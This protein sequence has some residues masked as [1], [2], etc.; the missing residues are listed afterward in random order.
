MQ[1]LLGNNFVFTN[2]STGTSPLNYKWTFGDGGND[3]QVNSIHHYNISGTY[4]VNL[5]ATTTAGCADTII[6]PAIVH[7]QPTASFTIVANGQCSNN[8][9]YTFTNTSTIST[10]SINNSWSFGDGGTSNLAS[11]THIYTSGT[12]FPVRLITI[13]DKGCRDTANQTIVVN[14]KPIVA[15][16]INNPGQCVNTNNFS[17]NNTSTAINPVSYIWSLGDGTTAS[18]VNANHI[19]SNDSTYSVKLLVNGNGCLDSLTK[20]VTVYP[21]P[22]PAFTV[23]KAMQCLVGNSFAITNSSIISSGTMQYQWHFG[24]GTIGNQLNPVHNYTAAGLYTINEFAT[25]NFGCI[26]STKQVVEVLVNPRARFSVNNSTQCLNDNNFVFANN[27]IAPT[28]TSFTWSFGDGTSSNASSP[29]KKYSTASAYKV[30][31]YLSATNGCKSDTATTAVSVIP[32]PIVNAGSDL[33]VVEGKTIMLNASVEYGLTFKWSPSTYLSSTDVQTPL[34]TPR[35]NIGYRLT[36][37]GQNGCIGSDSVYVKI[38]KALNIPNVFSPNGDGVNDKWILRSLSE[39]PGCTVEVFNRYGAS[40]FSSIG[41]RI[42]W[43]GTRNGTQ[44]PVGTYYY[45]ID[46]KNGLDKVSGNVTILR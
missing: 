4:P 37:Y 39:Y 15:F 21:K 8:N 33:V 10:G 40:V 22:V 1:C 42:P 41:Y 34:T 46:P 30:N 16:T 28:G 6:H 45:I 29:S 13:S 38:L 36:A 43:D 32:N 14:P 12:T 7:P 31:L 24:D 11:P 35:Q 44:L 9:N 20:I 17:F 2:V 23:D 27:S 3:N 5:I 18:T 25:S 19:Y 26:D